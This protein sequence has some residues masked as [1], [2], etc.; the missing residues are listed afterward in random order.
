MIFSAGT[1]KTAAAARKEADPVIRGLGLD[2]CE[3]ARMEKLLKDDRFLNRWFTEE[4]IRY[5]R[6]KGKNSAQTMAGIF[7]AKEAF[8]K[9]LGTGI[10]FDL[11]DVGI[12][13]DEEGQPGY[14]LSG[15]AAGLAAGGR[16]FLSISHE[17]GVSAAVCIREEEK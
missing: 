6:S 13:H 2:I 8:A 10:A 16:F 14:A 15:E 9:A 7:A 12:I 3:I 5:I 4:E 17:A 11:K 1:R